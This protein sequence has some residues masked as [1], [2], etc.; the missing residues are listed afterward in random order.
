[1]DCPTTTEVGTWIHC[2]ALYWRYLT[3]H[4]W[5]SLL[6]PPHWEC[7]LRQK[8]G[9]RRVGRCCVFYCRVS[10]SERQ[11]FLSAAVVE[12]T[13]I[14]SLCDVGQNQQQGFLRG[15]IRGSTAQHA[16]WGPLQQTQ[17]HLRMLITSFNIAMCVLCSCFG[18]YALWKIGV[19][20]L[21][22]KEW[23]YPDKSPSTC[24]RFFML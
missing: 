22:C 12:V 2:L 14:R 17:I 18:W 19:S 21:N 5:R 13:N 10:E 4:E 23:I 3:I 16:A 24:Q 20:L 1:M 9:R 11:V 8:A 15:Q 7:E 6:L